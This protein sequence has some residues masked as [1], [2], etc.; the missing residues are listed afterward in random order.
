MRMGSMY[1]DDGVIEERQANRSEHSIFE[2]IRAVTLEKQNP[3]YW[4]QLFDGRSSRHCFMSEDGKFLYHLGIIDY[5]QDFNIEKWGENKFKSL[6]S[7]GEMISAVPPKK[8]ALRYFNFMQQQ[9]VV[10]Q[11]AV[12]ITVKEKEL[13]KIQKKY[14]LESVRSE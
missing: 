6:I 4:K 14:R 8:Y 5:L 9:V 11:E 2:S 10:N 7:D 3:E 13:S 1:Y 12:N